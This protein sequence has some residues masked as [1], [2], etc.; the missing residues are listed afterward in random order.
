MNTIATR[1]GTVRGLDNGKVKSYLGIRYGEPPTGQHR[2]MPPVMAPAWRGTLDAS[3]YPNRAMQ[4]RDTGS[5]G[6]K[7]AGELSEDC[8]FLNIVTPSTSGNLRPVLVWIHGGGFV[9]GSANEYDGTVLA[10]Q[11]DVVVVTVNFRLGTF[12][13]LD[14]SS[15]GPGYEGSASNGVQDLILALQWVQDNI[16][17]YGGDPGNVTIFGESS[18]GTLVLSL[19]AAPAADR[20][21]HKAIAHSATCAYKA[22]YDQTE[23]LALRL[24]VGNDEYLDKLRSMTATEIV[25][26]GLRFRVSVDG[27][28]ITRPTFD[29]ITDRGTAGVPLLTGTNLNEGTLYTEGDDEAKDHYPSMNHLLA[30]EMLLGEDPDFYLESLREAYPDASPG[31]IHEMLW[32]DMFRRTCTLAAQLSTIAGPGGWL[33]RFD[34]PANLPEFRRFGATHSSEMAFTFNTFANPGT[35]GRTFH[36]RNDPVVRRVAREWSDAIIRMAR[37]GDPTG[38][39]LPAWPVYEPRDRQCLIV[40]ENIRIESD[41][42]SLHRSL[43]GQ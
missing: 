40:D 16:E 2:F 8:L 31:K 38:G 23:K 11:G 30:T 4:D 1:L 28:V 14:L 26:L 42:D 27:Q 15:Q 25:E 20:L 32:T 10:E 24:G 17:D 13:F 37:S 39:E 36:D 21:F 33:Y 9:S 6:Q 7:V 43:W 5:L 3:R 22:A 18:G 34:L 12:G 35:H 19:L 41:P 29:A